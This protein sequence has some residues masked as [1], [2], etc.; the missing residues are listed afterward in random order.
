MRRREIH[1]L[2]RDDEPLPQR[3]FVL[4]GGLGA[5]RLH[6]YDAGGAE[7]GEPLLASYAGVG[8]MAT[9]LFMR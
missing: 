6:F 4:R 2:R 9:V 8:D 1:L 7:I 5:V 3:G